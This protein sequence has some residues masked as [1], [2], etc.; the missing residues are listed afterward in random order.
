MLAAVGVA[1]I[2]AW[3]APTEAAPRRGRSTDDALAHVQPKAPRQAYMDFLA[4]MGVEDDQRMVLEVA[5]STYASG[6]AALAEELDEKAEAA[7][8]SRVESALEGAVILSPEE[9]RR[10]RIAVLRAYAEGWDDADALLEELLLNT[11]VLL[12]EGQSAAFEDALAT[13]HREIYLHPLQAQSDDETYAGDGVDLFQLVEEARREG[14]ELETLPAGTLEGVLDQYAAALDSLLVA[15]ANWQ[16]KGEL[17]QAIAR[18]ERDEDALAEAERAALNRWRAAYGLLEGAAGEIGEIVGRELGPTAAARWDQRVRE[19]TFPW[20]YGEQLPDRQYRWIAR[21]DLP[22]E[23]LARAKAIH[24]AF[25]EQQAELA[26]DAGDLIIQARKKYG[27]ILRGS[28]NPADLRDAGA[29]DLYQRFLRNSGQ[30]SKLHGDTS[31]KLNA[32][33]TE[34]QSQQMRSELAAE[35]YGRRPVR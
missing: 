15:Q 9:M 10:L 16:R 29:R 8:R 2:A 4:E 34:R 7:G 31:G 3:S 6:L 13:L 26:A 23:K 33:L 25:A 28:M 22:T 32:L 11:E 21:Q 20:L 19:A 14:G 30:R 27:L 1:L 12:D 5:Y 17:D 24:D 35:A 18:I